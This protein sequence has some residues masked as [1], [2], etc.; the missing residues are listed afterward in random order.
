MSNYTKTTACVILV[1]FCNTLALAQSEQNSNAASQ[2][3][4][5]IYKP[6]D[7][8]KSVEIISKPNAEY[9]SVARENNVTGSVFLWVVFR[10]SGAVTNIRIKSGLPFG[11]S[12]NAIAA[13]RKIK[14]K[15]AE[16]DGQRVSV[17][18]TLEYAFKLP[19]N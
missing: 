2:S 19:K 7:V 10:S 11:L 16:K 14:F 17:L 4:E 6:S 9:T 12:E 13:A 3:E 15:R 8:T 5:V 18:M 1:V